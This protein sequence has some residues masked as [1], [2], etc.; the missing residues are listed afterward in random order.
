MYNDNFKS[1]KPKYTGYPTI[2]IKDW[3]RI[4]LTGVL[5]KFDKE[6]VL[7]G[8]L[9]LNFLSKRIQSVKSLIEKR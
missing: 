3:I 2:G 7:K 8:I 6:N 5:R 1:E 9:N 4:I